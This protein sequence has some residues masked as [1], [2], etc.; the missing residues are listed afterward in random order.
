MVIWTVNRK[1]D[2]HE[3]FFAK[4]GTAYAATHIY[5]TQQTGAAD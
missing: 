1:N 2:I 4:H 5:R 3:I